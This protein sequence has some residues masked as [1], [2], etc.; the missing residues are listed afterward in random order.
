M[1]AGQHA[2]DLDAQLQDFGAE[3]LRAL[4]LPGL[5]AS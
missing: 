4:Q 2:A 5:L 3:C 1:L